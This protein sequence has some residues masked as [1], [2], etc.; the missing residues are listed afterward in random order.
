M[1]KIDENFEQLMLLKSITKKTG[2]LHEAQVLQLKMYP[3]V[4]THATKSEF[5][6]DFNKKAIIFTITEVKGKT[7]KNIEERLDLLISYTK[8]LLGNEYSVEVKFKDSQFPGIDKNGRKQSNTK[9]RTV[10]RR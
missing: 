6:F 1:D 2:G 9:G 8:T 7:P 10:K 3:L 5:S 4:L